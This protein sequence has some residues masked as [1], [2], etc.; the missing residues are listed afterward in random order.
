MTLVEAPGSVPRPPTQAAMAVCDGSMNDR[1]GAAALASVEEL[2]LMVSM[3]L[4]VV[5]EGK[6][7]REGH[8]LMLIRSIS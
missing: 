8:D 3:W 2:K 4:R 6:E 1:M 5:V 7:E